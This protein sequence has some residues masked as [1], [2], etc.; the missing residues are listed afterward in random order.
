M[1]ITKTSKLTKVGEEIADRLLN[2]RKRELELIIDLTDEQI[3]GQAMRIVEP[4]IWELGHVGWFQDRWILQHLDKRKPADEKADSLY[5]SF[6]IPNVERWDLFFPSRGQTLEYITDILE[7]IILRLEG[8][9][10]TDE[11]IYFYNLAL[12]HEDMHTETM[13]HIRHTLAYSAPTLS[14]VV[15][16]QHTPEIDDQFELH[17]V[18]IPGGTYMLGGTPDLPF[19]FDNEKWAHDVKVKPFSISA[20]PVIFAEYQKF[21][22]EGGYLERSIWSDE[23]W[24]W[25]EKSGQQNPIY[26]KK[27]NQGQ[28]I[29]RWFDQWND[30]EPFLPMVNVNWYE[31]NAYCEW[32]GRRLPTEAEWELAASATCPIRNTPI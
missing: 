19:I 26:W 1:E 27:D 12:N 16:A 2:S 13:H 29:W 31:A 18:E 30:F 4:P 3:V 11:E 5:D 8:H 6:N 22:D 14:D 32:T 25:K 28:W 7:K 20:T 17:D 24:E 9:E 21:V 10:P 23:G 15:N